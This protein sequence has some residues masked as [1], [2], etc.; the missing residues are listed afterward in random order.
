[1]SII[2]KQFGKQG[3]NYVADHL[4]KQ[5]FILLAHNYVQRCGEIDLIV[6]NTQENLLVFVEVKMRTATY[7]PL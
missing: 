7:F 4:K 2:R 3:E 1:M 6:Q 5:G